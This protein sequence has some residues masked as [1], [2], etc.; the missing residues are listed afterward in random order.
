LKKKTGMLCWVNVVVG[1]GVGV[2]CGNG[3]DEQ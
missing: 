2:G 1:G 3:S